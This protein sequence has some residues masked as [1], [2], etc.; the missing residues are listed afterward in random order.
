M[1]RKNTKKRRKS[2]GRKLEFTIYAIGVIIVILIVSMM[3][4]MVGCVCSED[5]PINT[6]SSGVESLNST[7]S[8]V[9]SISSDVESSQEDSSKVTSSSSSSFTKH[10]LSNGDYINYTKSGVDEL[11][12]WY[13][14]LVNKDNRLASK[15]APSSL[16]TVHV[17]NYNYKLDSR[18]V[19]AYKDMVAAAARD[20]LNLYPVSAYRTVDVQNSNFNNKVQ[21]VL[22]SNPS[23]TREQAEAE[24]ATAVARPRTSE[25]ECGLAV[26]FIDVE[27][28]FANT[29]EGKWLRE[30]CTDYGFILRYEKSKQSITGVIY[31]PWHF[32][33]VG[34]KHAKRIE[35]LGMCLEEY[36]DHI[37][38][39]GN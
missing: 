30:N 36:V 23:L 6:E 26:D 14:I 11:N 12:E 8:D 1:S 31:E 19:T 33:F 35:Q 32:R 18:V 15:W 37:K 9:S 39:G 17:S 7:V 29:K 10:T 27:E 4:N 38:N 20:G 34:I 24:A 5:D 3:I 2:G 16:T 13:L 22:K 28:R 25:H 21:R